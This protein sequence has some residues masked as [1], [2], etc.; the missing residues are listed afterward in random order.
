M[1][2]E[3]NYRKVIFTMASTIQ[4]PKKKK[5][6][7]K[8][9]VIISVFLFFVV[10]G[11]LFASVKLFNLPSVQI[12]KVEVSGTK[13]LS[14]DIFVKRVEGEIAGKYYFFYPKRNTLLYP[15]TQIEN[16]I[17]AE[18][19]GVSEVLLDVDSTHTLLVTIKE[20][21]PSAIWC[22]KERPIE[23]SIGNA[24]CYYIDTRGYIFGASPSFSGDAYFTF[25]GATLAKNK[26][27]LGQY[28]VSR[29]VFSRIL[30]LR[31]YLAEYHI[32][33]NNVYLGE[34][35]YAEFFVS[36][37]R[38]IVRW[39]TDQDMDAL[40]LNMGAVFRSSSWKG[41]TFTPELGSAKPL[42]YVDFRFGNKVFYK[43]KGVGAPDGAP[44]VEASTTV[45][46]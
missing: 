5:E 32:T 42:E 30:S 40:R 35:G 14:K 34:N 15:K 11:F 28:L 20:R 26:S 45:I 12:V 31:D 1:D 6:N 36:R 41:G 33:V 17:L 3:R 7:K 29:E 23:S 44:T 9:T 2:G 22:G 37:N 4:S 27:A 10:G 8:K 46:H 43:Q 19:P 21:T 39:N 25:Y 38:F 13:I 16:D 18:F 24:G